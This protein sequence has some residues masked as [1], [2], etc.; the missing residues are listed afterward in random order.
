ML[1]R[2]TRVRRTMIVIEEISNFK[3][4]SAIIY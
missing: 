3:E 1:I 4:R 2:I